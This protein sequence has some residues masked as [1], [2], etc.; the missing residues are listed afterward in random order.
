[1]RTQSLFSCRDHFLTC[2][3]ISQIF[4]LIP[5]LRRKNN[6]QDIAEVDLR[7]KTVSGANHSPY[8]KASSLHDPSSSNLSTNSSTSENELVDPRH[9][10]RHL[11]EGRSRTLLTRFL[12]R[13]G[14]EIDLAQ[15]LAV[16]E[17]K[18]VSNS[19]KSFH[20]RIVCPFRSDRFALHLA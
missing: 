2:N 5:I 20:N 7:R 4:R 19:T 12:Q 6:I 17:R 9:L 10:A 3:S 14:P 1:M 15:L 8:F 13:Y 11:S 18:L 16:S